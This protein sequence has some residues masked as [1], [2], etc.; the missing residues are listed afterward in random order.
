MRYLRYSN[1]HRAIMIQS[2]MTLNSAGNVA[3][4]QCWRMAQVFIQAAVSA[5]SFP[6]QT[7]DSLVALLSF[8]GAMRRPLY[9][10][11]T[12]Y[13]GLEIVKLTPQRA[14][15]IIEMRAIVLNEHDQLIMDGPY[16]YLVKKILPLAD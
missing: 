10:H 2:I 4:Q 1:W 14:T 13:L 15:G 3:T 7:A 6:Q 8:S 16:R 12:A 5:D 9:A 11:D